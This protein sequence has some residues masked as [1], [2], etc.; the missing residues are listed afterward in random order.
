[1]RIR[2][3]KRLEVDGVR[4]RER[5]GAK[6]TLTASKTAVQLVTMLSHC[7]C[8]MYD[9]DNGA[10][11]GSLPVQKLKVRII[12]KLFIMSHRL[13]KHAHLQRLQHT[14]DEFW[15]GIHR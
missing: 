9:K 3:L 14:D 8:P 2:V 10:I 11:C 6:H 13:A 12:F 15:D 5:A 1:M 4:I 7:I